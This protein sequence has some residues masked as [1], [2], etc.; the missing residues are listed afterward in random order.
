MKLKVGCCGFPVRRDMYFEK[1][2]V[3]EIQQTF[4]H[5][6]QEK[7]AIRWRQAAPAGFEPAGG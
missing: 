4:Y 6:P 1:F 7:T 5:P 3:V 2:S